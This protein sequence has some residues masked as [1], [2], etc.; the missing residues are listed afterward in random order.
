MFDR[1]FALGAKSR[2]LKDMQQDLDDDI[3]NNVHPS[4]HAE[5]RRSTNEH[6]STEELTRCKL[7]CL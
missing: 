1:L 2:T 7:P 4:Y 3:N 6:G 5:R